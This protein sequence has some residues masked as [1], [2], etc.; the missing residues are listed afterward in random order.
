VYKKTE[1][2]YSLK[3]KASR[4]FYSEIKKSNATMPFT[5]RSLP[6]IKTVSAEF[7]AVSRRPAT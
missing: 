6:D 7:C 1:V 5:L 4:A 3:M 2:P